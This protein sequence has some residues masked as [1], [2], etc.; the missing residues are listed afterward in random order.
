MAHLVPLGTPPALLRFMVIIELLR[1]L[2]RPITFSVRLAANIVAGHL[3]F[4]LLRSQAFPAPVLG[5]TNIVVVGALILLGGL[6][7]AVALIQGYVFRLLRTL[8]VQEVQTSRI[9]N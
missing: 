8:Y 6:E 4:V 9:A 5:L 2:I 1:R 7:T 3:L